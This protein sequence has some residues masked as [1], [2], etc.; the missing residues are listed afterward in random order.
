MKKVKTVY[1][2]DDNIKKLLELQAKSI[3]K[4]IKHVS[5]SKIINQVL[6]KRLEKGI[7]YNL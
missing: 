3:E 2:Y 7:Q 1:M 6:E 5:I 4:T